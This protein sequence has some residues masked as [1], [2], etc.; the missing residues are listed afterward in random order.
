[1]DTI[2]MPYIFNVVFFLFFSKV[3]IPTSRL[4]LS[5]CLCGHWLD[6]ALFVLL[7]CIFH[8]WSN[9]IHRKFGL[10]FELVR[11]T[12]ESAK[13][14]RFDGGSLSTVW[15]ICWT[16]FDPL[17]FGIF[18]QSKIRMDLVFYDFNEIYHFQ[19]LKSSSSYYV[20]FRNFT[21]I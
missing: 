6:L 4:F 14:Y 2:L 20:L 7:F 11:A 19:I 5:G 15:T 16:Q 8:H 13:S 10:W 17:Y 9:G 18:W 1:M 3:F 21:Q 12:L